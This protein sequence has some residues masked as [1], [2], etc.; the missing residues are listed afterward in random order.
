MKKY[1]FTILL[2]F[3]GLHFSNAQ[4]ENLDTLLFELPDV[5]FTK[6]ESTEGYEASYELKIKQPLDHFDSSKGFFYQRVFL[7]HKGFDRPT[8]IITEGYSRKQNII[9][10]LTD[11]LS[12]NQNSPVQ[13][14]IFCF[15]INFRIRRRH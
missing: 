3:I 11:F 8:V 4:V 5:I 12:A 14:F 9:Y 7:S 13:F 6:I 10:E 1:F 2:F 15:Q